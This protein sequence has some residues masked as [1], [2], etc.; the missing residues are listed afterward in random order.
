MVT[1]NLDEIAV[2]PLSIINTDGGNVRHIIKNTDNNFNGFGE[3]Y[4]SDIDPGYIKA[5]KRHNR[6]H[7][8]LVVPVGSVKFVFYQEEATSFREEEIGE[9][10]YS[11]I[12]VPPGIWF[13]FKGTSTSKSIVLNIANITHQPDEVSRMDQSQ[14]NYKWS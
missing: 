2:I 8:N 5:W 12:S 7:M 3:A 1:I 4:F 10:N 11:L 9:E 14:F 13:G 6:M